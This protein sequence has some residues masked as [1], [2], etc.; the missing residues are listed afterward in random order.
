MCIRDRLQKKYKAYGGITTCLTVHP[1]GDNFLV[2][3]T[4]NHTIWYDCDFSD[5]PYK[6]MKS[7]HGVVNAVEYHRN[8]DA[9]PLFASGASDGQVHVFHGMVYDDYT[10]NAL[11]VPVKIL[12]HSR[13]VYD[14][15][16]HPSLPWVFTSTEDGTVCCWTE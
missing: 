10:K 15:A 8:T 12:R 5:K 2:G 14:V 4:T 9:Y 11:I 13:P 16:W 7:H 3:D 6:R 1:D